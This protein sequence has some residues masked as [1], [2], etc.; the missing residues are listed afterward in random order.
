M[1]AKPALLA[2][3]AAVALVAAAAGLWLGQGAAP[4][5][6]AIPVP[7][8]QGVT[9][10]DAI[11]NEPGPA[12]LTSRF[13]FLAPDV[14][15]LDAEVAE[16]DMEALCQTYALPRIPSAGPQPAQIVISLSDRVVPFGETAPDAVQLF[17]AFS[18][19]GGSCIW[20][21]F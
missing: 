15:S 18:P 14:A 7:S 20:E 6:G 3:A 8:G 12:G 21:L 5:A 10:M 17:A 16:A 13:R 11:A 19:E 2:L 1:A 4:P 9:F